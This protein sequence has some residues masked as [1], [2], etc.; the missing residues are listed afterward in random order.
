M[1]RHIPKQRVSS[2]YPLGAPIGGIDDTSSLANMDSSYAIDLINFFPEFGSLKVRS[3]YEEHVTGLTGNGKTLMTFDNANGTSKLFCATDS[4]IFDVTNSTAAPTNVKALT[5]GRMIWAQFSN[6]AGQWLI[7]CNGVDAPVIYN[8]TTWTSFANVASPVNP[9]EITTGTITVANINY[10]AV[11]KNRIWFIEKNT[12]SAWYLNLNAVSGTATK[13]PLGGIFSKGGNL[14][15]MF[16]LTMD[17]GVGTDDI[18]VFQSSEGELGGYAGG[19]PDSST[20]WGLVARY[21]V[22]PPLGNRTH[23][24]LSGDTILLTEFGVVPALSIV[25][26][27]YRLGDSNT[28]ASRRISRTINAIV[29]RTA[30]APNWEIMNS[31]SFQYLLINLPATATV[32]AQQLVMNSVTGAWT[33]FDLPAITLHEFD[34]F[35]YF[36]DASGRV[37]KYGDVNRDG[38]L[39]N[40]TGGSQIIAGVQQAYS[41]FDSPTTNKHFK[42]VRPI[43]EAQYIPGRNITIS[44]DY[45]P[46]TL[47]DLGAP[48]AQ[49]SIVSIWDIATWDGDSWTS[50][51]SAW[52]TLAGVYGVGYSAS[53]IMKIRV[54][55]ETRFVATH[56]IFEGGISL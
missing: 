45:A 14:S 13:F 50:Q 46:T 44:T 23:V 29:R 8:G 20:D 36:T 18:L 10:V 15:T 25:S 52:Q 4:G 30:G 38:I 40:D 26:G 55:V 32:A 51:L 56:W 2:V 54:Q 47:D 3:G 48:S 9:G 12:M 7:A 31:S 28:T 6:I 27:Q 37:L 41:F 24:Q 42:F 1:G 17:S 34:Q 35:I 53:L 16:S 22:G 19:N 5:N 39:L 49:S 11:H 33:K 43:F 21:F